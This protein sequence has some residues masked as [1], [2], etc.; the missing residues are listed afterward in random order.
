MSNKMKQT[1]LNFGKRSLSPVADSVAK[2]PRLSE[3][4]ASTSKVPL[5]PNPIPAIPFDVDKFR[6]EL[7]TSASPSERDLLE[8]EL[9]IGESWLKVLHKELKKDYFLKLKRFL[10]DEGLRGKEVKQ[11]KIFPAGASCPHVALHRSRTASWRYLFL[12]SV[13]ASGQ[14]QSSHTGA[15]SVSQRRT[16]SW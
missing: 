12:E 16:G 6:S 15:R 7:S 8:L 10:W 4:V 5:A 13:H 9:D 2:K 1:A 3:P 14:G 11:N